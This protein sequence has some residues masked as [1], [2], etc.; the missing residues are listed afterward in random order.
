LG[1]QRHK[2]DAILESHRAAVEEQIA[3]AHMGDV[4]P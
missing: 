1:V 3:P 2:G 4:A